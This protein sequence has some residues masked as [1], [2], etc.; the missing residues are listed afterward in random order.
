M[1]IRRIIILCV[2]MVAQCLT[3]SG[4]AQ[5]LPTQENPVAQQPYGKPP[6]GYRLQ[7]TKICMQETRMGP[8]GRP[9]PVK[10]FSIPVATWVPIDNCLKMN[11]DGQLIAVPGDCGVA[12]PKVESC[13]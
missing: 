13:E 1:T 11:A 4:F 8:C 3:Q 9:L 5:Q 7:Q 6:A 12:P 2:F 10:R